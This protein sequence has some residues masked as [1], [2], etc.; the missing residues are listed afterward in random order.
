MFRGF[1]AV[2]SWGAKH[3]Y[4]ARESVWHPF[5]HSSLHRESTGRAPCST[6]VPGCAS[7]HHTSQL[8]RSSPKQAAHEAS[9]HPF[10]TQHAFESITHFY[11]T[12]R[13]LTVH[14]CTLGWG[15]TDPR[16]G[17]DQVI[18]TGMLNLAG[19]YCSL[20]EMPSSSDHWAWFGC[21]RGK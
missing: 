12:P 11:A 5:P 16:P 15:E 20:L 7:S 8:S 9:L 10:Q 3:M 6:P 1:S 17:K 2:K 14:G 4:S 18:H 13:L 19:Y 21:K